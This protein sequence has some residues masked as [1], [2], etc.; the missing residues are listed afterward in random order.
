V[1]DEGLEPE[2]A[3][4]RPRLHP[5][6]GIVHLEPGFE[7]AVPAA[8]EAAGYAVRAWPERHHYFGGVSVVSRSGAAGDPRRSGGATVLR[9][10]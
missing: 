3:V 1:L 5:A 2:T 7:D 9:P 4:E 8:L 6:A 10:S